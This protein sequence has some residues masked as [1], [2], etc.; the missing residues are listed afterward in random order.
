MTTT[1]TLLH[2]ARSSAIY[3]ELGSFVGADAVSEA[4]TATEEVVS[5]IEKKLLPK[6]VSRLS[7]VLLLF[8]ILSSFLYWSS[9][10]LPLSGYLHAGI[11]WLSI[12]TLTA[13]ILRLIKGRQDMFLLAALF[14]HSLG[15]L[16]LAHPYQDLLM[17]SIGPFLLGHIF[18]IFAFKH[19][20]PKTY[21]ALKQ[22]LSR[23]RKI[24]LAA[25]FIYT[26]IMGCILFPPL[27]NSHLF[28]PVI[29]YMAV[30]TTMVI[31]STLSPYRS[32]WMT[33]GCWMYIVSDSLIAI[34][35]FYA[36]LPPMLDACSW[37]LYYIGQILISLGLMKEKRSLC[38]L[39]VHE[40]FS[41]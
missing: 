26:G 19:D 14:C 27:I 37:P 29:V 20:L 24:L 32:P 6:R 2:R 21:L 15:D 34:N 4:V 40:Y 16:V 18:Y 10:V 31:L 7:Q 13:I 11:K 38:F 28:Y 9:L 30:V 22:T 23:A 1:T 35:K 36:P 41:I 12:G 8:S 25:A 33:L 39:I 3:R 5:E 17:Y